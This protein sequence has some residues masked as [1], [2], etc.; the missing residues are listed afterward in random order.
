MAALL[1]LFLAA[2]GGAH[3]QD[4]GSYG[5]C[6]PIEEEDIREAFRPR[7]APK[8]NKSFH[9]DPPS[10]LEIASTY[11]AL[12]FDPTIKMKKEVRDLEGNVIVKKGETINPLET[13]SLFEDLLFFD[14]ED[15]LQVAWAKEQKGRWILVNG[16]PSE[17]EEEEERPV[18][19]DQMGVL[20]ERFD[21]E[22]IPCKISQ[23]GLFLKIEEFPLEE[24]V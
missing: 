4:L 18:Y 15:P 7:S 20:T 22:K 12:S 6:Y 17:L 24:D 3:A 19:F 10:G 2:F 9:P 8:I 5:T 14:G 16:S 21:L 23:E 11:R 13:V 1:T